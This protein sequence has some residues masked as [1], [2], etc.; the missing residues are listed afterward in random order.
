MDAMQISES[1]L[2]QAGRQYFS[3]QDA[4]TW[5]GLLRPAFHLRALAEDEQVAGYLGGDPL[6]PAGIEWPQWDEHGPLNFVAAIDCSQ[7]PARELDIPLPEAGQLL[8]FYFDGLG[9]NTVAYTDPDSVIHGTRVLYLAADA[10]VAVRTAPEGLTPYPRLLLG[11]E[12]IATAPDNENAALIAAYGDPD[13][14]VAYCDYPTTEADGN[15]F[16]DEL[17]AFRRDHWP[18]H[19]IGGY[20]LPV[21]GSVEPEAAHVF[22]PGKEEQAT[23]ARKELASELVLLAQIDSDS[24][25]G[26]GW[27]DAGRLYWMIRRDDLAAG[28]FDKATFT[29]QCE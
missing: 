20:A 12:M 11:G 13:D 14:P 26:M 18:H 16:W 4:E 8:F 7:V 1:P 23:A 29:W 9:D 22:H 25:S 28:R 3:A 6:L 17:S 15:G 2:A 24:R 5:I 27:G 19:R 21:Q 10:D